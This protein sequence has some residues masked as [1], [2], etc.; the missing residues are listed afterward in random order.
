VFASRDP[1]ICGNLGSDPE[2]LRVHFIQY[3]GQN[4]GSLAV[5]D[6]IVAKR[7]VIW[8]GFFQTL[9]IG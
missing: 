6:A 2:R 8:A 3:F 4:L 9:P 5:N 7:F 1:D